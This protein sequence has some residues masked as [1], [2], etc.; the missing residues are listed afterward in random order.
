MS[1]TPLHS[2]QRNDAWNA[3]RLKPAPLLAFQRNDSWNESRISMPFRSTTPLGVERRNGRNG[4]KDMPRL[5]TLKPTLPV[6]GSNLSIVTPGSWRSGKHGSTARGY[7]YRWQKARER[8]LQM[9]PLCVMCEA[10]SP[11]RVSA[12]TIVDHRIPHR[13]DER[14][15]WDETNWQ[16]LCATHHSGEK[17]RQERGV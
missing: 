4:R 13:G 17:Q 2:F 11:P 10:E 8:H 7:G 15:F 1:G 5:K 16:S 6:L 12:A 3:E 14:L 9:H